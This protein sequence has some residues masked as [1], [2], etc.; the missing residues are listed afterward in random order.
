MQTH[1]K[2]ARALFAI[3]F[4]LA[5]FWALRL[6][7]ADFLFRS[8]SPENVRR[9]AELVPLNPEYQAR[10]GNLRR[11]V[12]LNPYYS[13]AW[14]D[15]AL[16]AET[17]GDTA[18]AERFLLQAAR[19]DQTFEPRWALANF[20]LRRDNPEQF[21]KWLR[22]SAERSH[23]DRT[24]IFR[25]ASRMTNDAAEIQRKAI[26]QDPVMLEAWL[27]HLLA[28]RNMDAVPGAASALLPVIAE[29]SSQILLKA[30]EELL[31]S[32]RT[33]DAVHV[34]NGM[35]ARKL[36]TYPPFHPE[37]GASLTNGDLSV[38]PLGTAFDWRLLWREGV[39]SRWYQS[40]Q[41]RIALNGK[42]LEQ[43]DLLEQ[44][45]PVLPERSYEFC[46]RYRTDGFPPKTGLRWRVLDVATPKL[47]AEA[48]APPGEQQQHSLNFRTA[49]GCQ[50]IRLQ[51]IYQREPGTV[52]PEGTIVFDGAFK[53]ALTR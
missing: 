28:E 35:A 40:R 42:Q 26:P 43:T 39:D 18:E 46:Y 12:E 31:K 17:R 5:A 36:L 15:L 2:V 10:V 1:H 8:G 23:G 33:S 30:C 11:A 13:S 34:W 6:A 9:A 25:L 51:L 7:Y 4:L 49:K 44:L 50:L 38:Q 21:W 20:Y 47:L 22:L 24:A 53:L 14:I 19:F 41:I 3:P 27:A 32:G 45:A 52:R 37:A 48:I 29:G 16:A